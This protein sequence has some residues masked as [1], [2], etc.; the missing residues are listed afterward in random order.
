MRSTT[1]AGRQPSPLT[2]TGASVAP[3]ALLTPG[4]SVVVVAEGLPEAHLVA[5]HDLEPADP[6]GALPEVDVRNQQP[7]APT[8]L[9]LEPAIVVRVGHPG[10]P[11]PHGLHL[12]VG[13]VAAVAEGGH[14]AAAHVHAL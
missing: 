2:A 4:I 5:L 14:V 7:R 8:V 9:G 10:L 1:S 6:L 11:A 3:E 12:Q 13:G